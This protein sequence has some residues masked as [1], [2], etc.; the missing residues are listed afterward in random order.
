MG[1]SQGKVS[2]QNVVSLD[3]LD[4]ITSAYCSVVVKL[5]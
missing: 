2:Q 5:S 4:C 1:N 3:H